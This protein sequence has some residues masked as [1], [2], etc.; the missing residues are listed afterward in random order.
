V[1]VTG[2]GDELFAGYSRTERTSGAKAIFK[3]NLSVRR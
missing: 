1:I 2:D 3:F